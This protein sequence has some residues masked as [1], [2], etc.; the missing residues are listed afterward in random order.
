MAIK[1]VKTFQYILKVDDDVY[2]RPSALPGAIHVW[3]HAEYVA[4]FRRKGKVRH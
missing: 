1:D 3:G 2:F 4:C